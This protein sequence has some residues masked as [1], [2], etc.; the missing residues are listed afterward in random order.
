M[1][2]GDANTKF[3]VPCFVFNQK[4]ISEV[5]EVKEV[6]LEVKELKKLIS[7]VKKLRS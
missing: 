4:L 5:K 2:A 6:N 1:T 3:S 7:E